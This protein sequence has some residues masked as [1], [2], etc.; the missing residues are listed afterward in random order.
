[1]DFLIELILS[2]IEEF[3]EWLSRPFINRIA[4]K[5]KRRRKK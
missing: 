1:M 2:F 5:R 4:A 3:L